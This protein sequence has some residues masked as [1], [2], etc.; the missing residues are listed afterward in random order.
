MS[1]LGWSLLGEIVRCGFGFCEKSLPSQLPTLFVLYS[2]VTFQ[3][4]WVFLRLFT[5]GFVEGVYVQI[6]VAVESR[7]N[8]VVFTP[9]YINHL[10]F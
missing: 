3:G 8:H 2:V 10:C 5:S 4:I 7:R 1:Q 9:V 6:E